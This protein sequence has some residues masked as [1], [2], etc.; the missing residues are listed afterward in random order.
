MSSAILISIIGRLLQF[1]ALAL[2]VPG[3]VGRH[4]GEPAA[5]AYF[6]TAGISFV[7]GVVLYVFARGRPGA[8]PAR[9]GCR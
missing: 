5:R 6:E 7:V 1:T 2:C 8:Y 3:L 9:A 4:Y